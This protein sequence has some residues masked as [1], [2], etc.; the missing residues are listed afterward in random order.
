[1]P[2]CRRGSH[3][4]C[5]PTRL[6]RAPNRSRG[7]N[8]IDRYQRQRKLTIVAN[9][10]NNKALGDAM[11]NVRDT[12]K[13]ANLPPGYGV[14]SDTFRFFKDDADEDSA[15]AVSCISVFSGTLTDAEV[16]AIG[17]SPTCTPAAPGPA[18]L[19]KKKKCK[20]KKHRAADAKKKCKKKKKRR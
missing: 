11:A 17:A 18:A 7:P 8:Q 13:A 5:V 6:Q 3:S 1:M 2:G 10:V 12:I 4:R 20:K 14:T 15:G 19:H 16:A 9:L